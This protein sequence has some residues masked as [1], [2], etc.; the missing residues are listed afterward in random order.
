MGRVLMETFIP[1]SLYNQ[2]E[3]LRVDNS[4]RLV[5]DNSSDRCIRS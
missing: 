3:P 4:N 1:R 5:R 2:T